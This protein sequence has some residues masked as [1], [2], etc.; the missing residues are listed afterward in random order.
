MTTKMNWPIVALWFVGSL[1]EAIVLARMATWAQ[2]TMMASPMSPILL[3]VACGAATA[4]LANYFAAISPATLRWGTVVVTLACIA[5]VHL[6]FYFDYREGFSRVFIGN[7]DPLVSKMNGH[8]QPVGF[9]EF[10]STGAMRSYGVLPGWLWWIVDGGLTIVASVV[11][12]IL[13]W[14]S[15]RQGARG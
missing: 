12:A 1:L 2:R 8:V 4:V 13:T 3:G 10:M 5:A 6:F 9:S 15:A 11:A 14:R 7:D